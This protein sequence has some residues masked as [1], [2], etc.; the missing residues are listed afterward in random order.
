MYQDEINNLA[1]VIYQ[2]LLKIRP[3]DEQSY[4][5]LALIYKQIGEYQFSSS[6]YNKIL[7]NQLK[8]VDILGLQK[9]VVNEASHLYWTQKDNLLLSEFP[10]KILRGFIPKNDWK[11]S[12]TSEIASKIEIQFEKEMR[13]IGYL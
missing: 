8:N 9:T 11:K 3:S 2:R 5:D 12:L 13:E 4:R 1:K 6:I 7:K 10:L